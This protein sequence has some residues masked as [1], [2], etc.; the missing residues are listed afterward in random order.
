[1]II[2]ALKSFENGLHKGKF[3]SVIALHRYLLLLLLFTTLIGE[4]VLG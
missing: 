4:R 2:T 1:M 3:S